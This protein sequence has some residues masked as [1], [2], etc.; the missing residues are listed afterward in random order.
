MV[1]YTL[2]E[3]VQLDLEVLRVN[4]DYQSNNP[5]CNNFILCLTFVDA[6]CLFLNEASTL[7]PC[8]M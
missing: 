1:T 4:Q 5:P 7:Q 2:L 3:D 6:R 8:I